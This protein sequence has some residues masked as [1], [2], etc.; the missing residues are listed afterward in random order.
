VADRCDPNPADGPTRRPIL[1]AVNVGF[2][3]HGFGALAPFLGVPAR[4]VD[5]LGGARVAVVGAPFDWGTTYRPG[6]RFGPKAIREGDHI[7]ADGSRP[8]LE[9]GI[10]ALAVLGVV[11]VGDVEL[12]PGYV[13]ESLARIRD[14]VERIARQGAVPVVLG[15]DHTVTFANAGAVAAVHGFG[16]VALV[17]FDAH[18]DTGVTH[19]G[20][21][22]GHGTPMRRL[23]ESGAVPGDRF[24]QIGL[25]GY[26]PP[27]DVVAWMAD[28]NMVT[29]P[30]GEIM[31][32][33]LDAVVD[34]AVAAATAGAA[35]VFVSVDIDVVDPSMAPGTGTPEPGGLTPRELLETLRRLGRSLDVVGAD[36][37]EVAPGYDGPGEVTAR[38]ANRLVLALLDGM[39]ERT[40]GVS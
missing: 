13:D 14:A 35:K 26:W 33:G 16:E 24:V 6:A 38:L 31:A 39:A 40:L 22:H 8:R 2:G 5:D 27:P 17:H 7:G 32:R 18:A 1:N 21:L 15:G 37:V 23:V 30:M 12:V 20:M 25:R 3:V 34:D 28:H 29:F 36:V 11:D 19:Y 4:P 9:T 10:D